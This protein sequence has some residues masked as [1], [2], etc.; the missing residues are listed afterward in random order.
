MKEVKVKNSDN[1]ADDDSYEHVY[2]PIS[3]DELEAIIA[4]EKPE[5][6]AKENRQTLDIEDVDWSILERKSGTGKT[7]LACSQ[8]TSRCLDG[9]CKYGGCMLD[10]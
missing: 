2:D 5:S 4:D 7:R 6:K 9:P 10:S 3:D 8:P 1:K